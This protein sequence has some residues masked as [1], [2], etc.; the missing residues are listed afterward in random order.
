MSNEQP[1]IIQLSQVL[2]SRVEIERVVL[3][4]SQVKHDIDA[5]VPGAITLSY[6]FKVRSASSEENGIRAVVSFQVTGDP[7]GSQ[8]VAEAR[9]HI[10]EVQAEFVAEYKLNS[11]DGIEP[12]NIDA[13]A[14]LNGVFNLWPYW[15][16]YVQSALNRMGLP[17]V[18][19]PVLTVK[20]L[21]QIYK[22]ED[23]KK[24]ALAQPAGD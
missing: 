9:K 21:V 3:V 12:A 14:K 24:S 15:R 18:I 11:S 22:E 4:S 13:F 1:T 5:S 7:E 6:G 19:V 16:E 23:E 17:S 20:A 10:F 2:T 8:E